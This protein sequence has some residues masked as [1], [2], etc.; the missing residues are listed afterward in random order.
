ML[1]GVLK[2]KVGNAD[3]IE[4]NVECLVSVSRAY[5]QLSHP[6]EHHLVLQISLSLPQ[7]SHQKND[8][9]VIS[10]IHNVMWLVQMFQFW[11]SDL[12]RVLSLI[13]TIE[14]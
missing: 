5:G 4:I 9:E 10:E 3:A 1:Q 13:Q 14:D 8:G 7:D 6:P 2:G 12:T 11:S